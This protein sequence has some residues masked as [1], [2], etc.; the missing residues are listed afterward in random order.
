MNGEF[1]HFIKT[2][3]LIFKHA[4]GERYF[5]GKE[6]H[7][8]H[9]VFLFLG[10]EAEIISD[11]MQEKLA[12][13]T[14]VLIPRGKFHQFTVKAGA[15]YERCIFNFGSV[16][17]LDQLV[18]KKLS[19]VTV[20]PVPCSSEQLE[21]LYRAAREAP[22][23]L[24]SKILAKAVL[25]ELLCLVNDDNVYDRTSSLHPIVRSAVDYIDS[26]ISDSI[27]I[28]DIASHLHISTSYLTRIFRTNMHI[29]VYRYITEKRLVN[30]ARLIKSGVPTTKAAEI[31]GFTDYSSFYRLY[32]TR[33]GK[34]PSETLSTWGV[35]D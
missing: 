23:T 26:H 34:A 12:T 32:K 11:T 29:S 9:E 17:E 24:E 16:R 33:F 20:M 13:N 6:F 18:E 5:V 25:A 19:E 10:G 4:R 14:L 2:D 3:E 30:A 15:E 21:R 27:C 7:T 35:A 8:F 22:D 28:G 31:S 1:T